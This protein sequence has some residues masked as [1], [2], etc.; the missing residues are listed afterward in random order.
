MKHK[1]PKILAFIALGM[2][3]VVAPPAGAQPSAMRVVVPFAFLAGDEVYQ[4]GMY[5][6]R[7]DENHITAELRSISG[8][9]MARIGLGSGFTG[10]ASQM[11]KGVLRF[12]QYGELWSLSGIWIGGAERGYKV[13]PGKTQSEL[14]KAHPEA[15]EVSIGG[16]H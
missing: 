7:V 11:S 8:T 15:V 9:Q 4:P 12:V 13:R 6:V 10:N 3:G 5:L 2:A 1:F 16:V 14:A